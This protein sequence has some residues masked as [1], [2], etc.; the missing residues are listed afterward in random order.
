MWAVDSETGP[1]LKKKYYT[2]IKTFI[3]K[4]FKTTC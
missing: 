1:V 2:Y 4:H 3:Q